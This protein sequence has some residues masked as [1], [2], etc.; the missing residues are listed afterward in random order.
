MKIKNCVV[1]NWKFLLGLFLCLSMIGLHALD[2]GHYADFYPIN[3]TFQNYNPVRRFLAGQL[4]YR[5][6]Q[7]YLGMG[8]LY[9]GTVFTLLFGGTYRS[10]LIA[11]SFLNFL[12]FSMIC[13]V[14]GWVVFKNK[15]HAICLT[16]IMIVL[17]LVNPLIFSNALVLTDE[18]KGSLSRALYVGN[19]ARL[20][21]GMALPLSCGLLILGKNIIHS[22][23]KK[24]TTYMYPVMAGL[25]AGITFA[26]SNDYGIS[27]WLCIAIMTFWYTLSFTRKIT[28]AIKYLTIEVFASM[29]GLFAVV[30][31]FTIGHFPEWLQ[32]TFGTGNYQSWYYNSDY[33]SYYLWDA[34]LSFAVMVQVGVCLYYLFKMFFADRE[35]L[36]LDHKDVMLAYVNMVSVCALQEYKLISGGDSIEVAMSVLFV[37]VFFELLYYAAKNMNGML[38]TLSL[39]TLISCGACIVSMA[40]NEFAFQYLTEKQGTYVEQLGGN[41]SRLGEDLL[42]TDKFLNGEKFFATYA[43][44]QE[45]VSGL[46]QPSGTDY[47]IHVLGD[48]QRDQYMK[49]F[50]EDDFKYTATIKESYSSWEY[51]VQRANWFFYRELYENWH[52]VFSNSYEVYWEKNTDEAAV[53]RDGFEV[54]ADTVS[55][56]AVKISVSC[57]SN[58]NGMADVYIDYAV[59]KEGGKLAKFIWDRTLK[60]ENTGTIYAVGDSNKEDSFY[61]SNFLRD[62]SSEYIPIPIINGYGEVTLTANPEKSTYL[63]LFDFECSKIYT[64]A[65]DYV[66]VSEIS[67]ENAMLIPASDKNKNALSGAVQMSYGDIDYT[68]KNIDSDE[69]WIYVSVVEPLQLSENNMARIVR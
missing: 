9:A 60:V 66:E 16:D 54:K 68:V 43:S 5:D 3:G 35:N 67:N 39:V 15:E 6:F 36:R 69:T 22:H 58:V 62:A 45:V 51:W 32:A 57:D 24:V 11:F 59:Q 50:R 8:H 10:S 53:I 19:S 7:D 28:T 40:K 12:A 14:I 52:P 46:Y 55:D 23:F 42:K 30:E 61:E 34:D 49:V 27:G 56:A 4:P 37:T 44:G 63:E 48:R 33:P 21:R 13:F 64:V 41:L 29:A 25:V 26:W 17:L 65:S 31:V 47:I 2:A 1:G 38:K 18:I 20:I